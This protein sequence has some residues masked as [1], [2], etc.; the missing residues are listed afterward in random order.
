MTRE[1]LPQNLPRCALLTQTSAIVLGANTMPAPHRGTTSS[2][3][4]EGAE[5]KPALP[6]L[7]SDVWQHIARLALAAEDG[8]TRVWARLSAVSTTFRAGI[9]CVVVPPE[10]LLAGG[11]V[12]GG[13]C[14]PRVPAVLL[15]SLRSTVVHTIKCL[16]A[17]QCSARGRASLHSPCCSRARGLTM[18]SL[19]HPAQGWPSLCASHTH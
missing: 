2:P 15:L 11:P 17:P 1:A 5:Q 8:D 14:V 6:Q 16:V 4:T 13:L 19:R 12:P 9:S 10:A 3:V 18:T 7:P